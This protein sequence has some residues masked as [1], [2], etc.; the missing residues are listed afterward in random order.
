M[1]LLKLSAPCALARCHEVFIAAC[2]VAT[3]SQRMQR[4]HQ[5]WLSLNLM[6]YHADDTSTVSAGARSQL[7]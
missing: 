3:V 6:L 2:A 7:Q 4:T 5:R 1:T